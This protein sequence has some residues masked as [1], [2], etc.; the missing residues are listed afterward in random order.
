MPT[1]TRITR[2]ELLKTAPAAL[3]LPLW[4]RHSTGA[5]D[6]VRPKRVAAIVT[7]YRHNSH[8]DVILTKIL[9]GWEHDGGPGPKL[10]LA[11]AYF[12]Q[13]PDADMA[14]SMCTKHNVPIF[15][16]I[17]SAITL[18]TDDIAVDGVICIG[19]HGDYPW[20]EKGQH[21]YPRYRFFTE[22][23]DTFEKHG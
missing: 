9:E 4:A 14:R 16:S 8:A 11:G 23:A 3:T 13:F 19:E 10:E 1:T 15:D 17:E 7:E 2:R 12:D 18:G 6:E 5:E 22:N 21:L 20:N